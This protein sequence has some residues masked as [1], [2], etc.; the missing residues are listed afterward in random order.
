MT[1]VYR[2]DDLMC[3]HNN[4]GICHSPARFNKDSQQCQNTDRVIGW[5]RW[6][7]VYSI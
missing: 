6:L 3:V 2:C 7:D 1:K 5:V 4:N